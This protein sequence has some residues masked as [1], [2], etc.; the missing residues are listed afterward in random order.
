MLIRSLIYA[1]FIYSSALLGNTADAPL[2]E[3]YATFYEVRNF[4]TE[5]TRLRLWPL[6]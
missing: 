1:N 5:F 6:S 3:K 4:G 2:V